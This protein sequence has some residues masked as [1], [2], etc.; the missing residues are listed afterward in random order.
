MPES[1]LPSRCKSSPLVAGIHAEGAEFHAEIS[2]GEGG[3]DLDLGNAVMAALEVAAEGFHIVDRRG[4]TVF[5]NQAASRIDGLEPGEVLGKHILDVFPSLDENTSTLL[6]VLKT[7]VPEVGRQ[8]T[9]FNFKGKKITTINNTYPILVGGEIAGAVEVSRDITDV[10]ELADR[11]IDLRK[12]LKRVSGTET[13][14][15]QERDRGIPPSRLYTFEDIVGESPCIRELRRR[16]VQIAR[17]DTPVLVW[18]ETGTGKEL[19]VQA[20]HSASDRR[21]FPFVP[22]NCAALPESLLEGLMFGTA[23]GG[24][25]GARDRPGLV[26]LASGGTLYLDELDSMP[27]GLQAKLL[28]AIQ[29]RKI[30]RLGD[31]RERAVDARIIA[32]TSVPPRTA[33]QSGKLRADLYYRLSVVELAVPPLRDR[34]EDIPLLVDHFLKKHGGPGKP[35][36][37]SPQVMA[38]FLAYD[39]PGNVRELEHAILGSMYFSKGGEIQLEDLP[40]SVRGVSLLAATYA[41]LGGTSPGALT[42]SASPFLPAQP[43]LPSSTVAAPRGASGG[44]LGTLREEARIKERAAIFEALSRAGTVAGAAR[45]MGIP[46]QT[47]QYRMKI[48]GIEMAMVKPVLDPAVQRGRHRNRP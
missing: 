40:A 12:E 29:E 41:P 15:Q 11:L 5:Y 27:T 23:A 26:E 28:R 25:T 45:L 4:I 18:G 6:K 24:F 31:V 44:P 30:R 9:F 48:L 47:L 17:G 13:G 10:R 43:P 21:D 34:K 7:G 38:A 37:V 46:R 22:Q 42:S 39:W 8:Q 33:V 14:A 2:A 36:R 16:A 32:S 20:I 1:P 35:T 3:G 19:V